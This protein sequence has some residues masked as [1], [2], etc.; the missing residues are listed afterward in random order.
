MEQ[1]DAPPEALVKL[2]EVY[3]RLRRLEEAGELTD[4]A[5]QKDGAC[6]SAQLLRAKLDRQAGQL[7]E[8]ENGSARSWQ[9][10]TG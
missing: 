4:R 6:A 10:P 7:V 8:A 3:E 5:L 1:N 9:N 2:A